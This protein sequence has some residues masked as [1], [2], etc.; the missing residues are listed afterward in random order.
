MRS[1]SRFFNISGVPHAYGEVMI[2]LMK[3]AAASAAAVV[4]SIDDDALDGSNPSADWDTRTLMNHFLLW[5]SYA[6]EKRA[7]R[8]EL[9]E[10]LTERDFLAAPG[11]RQDY[12]KHLDAALQAWAKPGALDGEINGGGGAM[13]AED[14]ASMLVLEL[15]LH[16][17]D[18]AKAT[19][20]PY[21]ADFGDE[22]LPVVE[23]WADMYRQYEG[24]G[25]AVELPAGASSLDRALALAGRDP[26]WPA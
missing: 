3:K 18:V 16:G 1:S 12:L 23:K 17:W 24:F 7:L 10:D 4:R 5:T 20:V 19:G 13:S 22:I 14:T 15:F 21:E 11:W 8:E 26:K 9:T 25:A 2:E 6:L